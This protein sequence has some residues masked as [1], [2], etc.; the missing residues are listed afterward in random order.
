MKNQNNSKTTIKNATKASMVKK[1]KNCFN[2]MQIKLNTT[3]D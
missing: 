3:N 2:Q 1:A